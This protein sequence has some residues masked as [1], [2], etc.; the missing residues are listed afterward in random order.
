MMRQMCA[1]LGAAVLTATVAACGSGG[2]AGGSA[3]A[4][5]A[6]AA[7]TGGGVPSGGGASST[8]GASS[9]GGSSSDGGGVALQVARTALGSV[10][11]GPDGHT[12]YLFGKDVKDSG[13]SSCSGPCL[14][15]WPPVTVTGT[16]R[17]IGIS[18]TVG[19]ITTDG[20]KQ[21]TLDGWPLYYYV[22]DASAGDVKGQGNTGFGGVWRA[23]MPN[24]ADITSGG[25]AATGSGGGGA[26]GGGKGG[27]GSY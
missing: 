16:P 12:V 20:K 7:S 21:L 14:G 24:G 27:Y 15:Y 18:G 6:R 4:T 1:A 23:M 3:S 10:V 19:T 25:A 17:T 11:V 22:G 8:G 2:S 13:K 9:G 5:G 26:G